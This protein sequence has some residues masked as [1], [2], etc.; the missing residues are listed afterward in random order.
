MVKSK[1]WNQ[2][3]RTVSFYSFF[4]SD[5]YPRCMLTANLRP[6]MMSVSLFQ[7]CACTVSLQLTLRPQRAG[8]DG[9]RNALRRK[10]CASDRYRPKNVRRRGRGCGTWVVS[11]FSTT[12]CGELL[13]LW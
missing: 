12:T 11:M 9:R 5:V 3:C 10:V 7:E 2:P 8:Q 1:E 13:Q 6:A 4:G